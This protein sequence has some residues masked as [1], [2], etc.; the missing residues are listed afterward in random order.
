MTVTRAWL[1]L[2]LF[3]AGSTA[4]AV[5]GL[6]GTGFVVAVLAL[7]GAKARVILS[8]YLGLA[9]APAV[10]TGFDLALAALLLLC[11]GLAIAG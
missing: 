3:S 2:L 5:S 10:L 9:A 7:A 8:R 1:M 6:R 4:L 11:A